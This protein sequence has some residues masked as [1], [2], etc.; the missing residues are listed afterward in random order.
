MGR[1]QSATGLISGIPVQDTIDKLLQ[2]A[3]QPRIL[4][5]GRVAKL[6]AQK[7]AVTELTALVIGI[8]LASQRLGKSELFGQTSVSSSDEDLLAVT[9]T[10]NPIPGS[11]Q[12][13]PIRRAQS[14]QLLSTGF[15]NKTN[16]IGAG[17]LS[18]QFGGFVDKGVRLEELNG[19]DGVQRG[20][21]R[22]TDRSGDSATIDLRLAVT[23]E[24][25]LR[26]INDN[27]DIRVEAVADG[28]RIKLIDHTGQ[29]TNNLRV[30]EVGS[31]TTAADLGLADINVAA[32][33]VTG[34]DILRLYDGLTLQ[35]LNDGNGVN[36]QKGVADLRT[37]LRDGSVVDVDFYGLKKGATESSATTAAKNGVNAQIKV[38]STG[39][40]ETFDGYKLVFE[41]DPTITSGN[42]T[43]SFD[44]GSK[45][46]KVKIDAGNTRA[47][48]VIAKLNAD[49][50][51]SASF[52]ASNGAGGNGTGV[53]DV[54]DTLTTAGGA[55]AY[56]N[57]S[58]IAD[59]IESINRAD[60]TKLSARIS[61]S[62]DSIELVDL[63]SGAGT[64]TVA[65]LFGGSVADDLGFNS[66]SV[67]GVITGER[68]WAGL[69]SVLLDSLAGGFGLGALGSL[70]ITNRTGVATSVDLASAET[71][72]DVIELINDANAGVT[73][74]VNAAR[75]GISLTD[76]TGGT[77]NLIIANGDATNTADKL[78]VATNAAT[79]TANSGSLSLQTF[80]E[81]LT[82]ASLRNGR[83]VQRG[84][85]L[86]TDT[87][88]NVG[89]VNLT[90][91]NAQTVGDVVDGINA[92]G[93]GVTARV[94]DTGDGLLLLDTAGGTGDLTVADV[95]SGTAAKDL[96]I[97]GTSV[98]KTI[99]GVPTKVI[100][101]SYTLRVTLDADDNLQ[102]LVTKINALSGD[103]AASIFN[104]GGGA[105]PFRVTINSQISGSAGE[106][107]IDG[108]NLNIGFEETAAAQDA[109]LLAGSLDASVPGALISSS[110]NNFNDVIEG[111]RL[112]VV[113]PT[114]TAQTITVEKKADTI[115]SQVKLLVDQFNKLREHIGDV[116]S[117]DAEQ[118]RTG[119]LFG[120]PDILQIDLEF[121]AALTSRFFSTGGIQSFAEIG[122]S[123]DTNGKLQFDEEKF[124]A[125]YAA[126]QEGVEEFFTHAGSG[127]AAK[128]EAAAERLAGVGNSTLVTRALSLQRTI[129]NQQRQ[130][131]A[132]NRTL[133][134]QREQMV[135]EF[136]R[137]EEVIARMQSNLSWIA[138]IQPIAFARSSGQ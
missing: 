105:T 74:R 96:K 45:T 10:G 5:E 83:G 138:K 13:T 69:K 30:Q 113:A 60:P 122:I 98:T 4:L 23:I 85:F 72:E 95:G 89:A 44:A 9:S 80:N 119:V 115:V 102:D 54:A 82:L 58:T 106:I 124:R 11:Y 40:G 87:N 93:L 100:D 75:N 33:E 31:T 71:L 114:T 77:S 25:V 43:V 136:A 46:F 6:K 32:D 65:S 28:D 90:V 92:L 21:I 123:P 38:T 118:N 26:A 116:A 37:T 79:S 76:T 7:L 131:D 133:E 48:E 16:A 24:D 128:L 14:H 56:Y 3:A 78:H 99:G 51:F 42:E 103:V 64:F 110:T 107:L 120:T 22:I 97:A 109:L 67:G 129:D 47:A 52:T 108:S 126:N 68:R 27:S 41:D 8:Q 35:R 104:S 125:K 49:T 20:R 130:I 94:N 70:S 50:T 91:L 112:T 88:G 101:G 81:N 18:M 63:T 127:G 111:L 55:I 39:T 137:L 36:F 53:V 134:R 117:F 15:A 19:G 84:S 59:L 2:I 57:E 17:E 1:I 61:T 66:P 34:E 12:Y 29:T 135:K 62:G 121:H 86:I 132:I 73:A